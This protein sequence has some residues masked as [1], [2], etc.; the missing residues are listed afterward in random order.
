MPRPVAKPP[1]GK[2]SPAQISE[3]TNPFQDGMPDT[4][5][6]IRNMSQHVRDQIL[7]KLVKGARNAP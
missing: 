7:D 1:L 6:L 2:S 4:G 5:V 3:P